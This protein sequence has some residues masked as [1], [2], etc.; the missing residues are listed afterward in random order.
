MKQSIFEK[1]RMITRRIICKLF[2]HSYGCCDNV[3][4]NCNNCEE[5]N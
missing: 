4:K 2:N 3:F 1:I 5:V